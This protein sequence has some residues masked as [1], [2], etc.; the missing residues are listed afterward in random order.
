[1]LNVLIV[2]CGNI[3]GGFDQDRP[4]SDT[5]FTHAGAYTRHG[6]F[7]VTACVEPDAVRREAFMRRWAVPRGFSSMQEVLQAGLHFDVVSICS[8]TAAHGDDA[9]TALQLHPR[10]I[11][12]EKPLT[13]SAADTAVL[14]A[15]CAEAG[16]LLAVNYI[17]RWDPEVM[18][19]AQQ[20]RNGV[21]GAVRAASGWYN[22]GVLNNGSHMI[23]L[24]YLLLGELE[25]CHVG[26]GMHDL[27]PDD[28]SLPALLRAAGDIPVQLNCGH[29][30]D[31]SLFE[32][33]LVTERGVIAIEE[34]GL[35]WRLRPAVESPN[36]RGYR[37]LGAD[38]RRPGGVGQAMLAAVGQI[39]DVL[40]QGGTL[41][42]TGENA[43]QAQRICEALRGRALAT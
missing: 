2:G 38:Q 7:T 40:H 13:T 1:M 3:A 25:V 32:L 30:G 10:L 34:G 8:P 15:R 39:H 21:W 19:L 33:Q 23:D 20:L 18:Q 6:G 26:P 28:P 9:L 24:L 29:A 12:C 43:L 35:Q 4:Q 27:L 16:M 42:S 17:R 11:F 14:T 36:F 41:S 5:P 22:K 31:Y 37:S